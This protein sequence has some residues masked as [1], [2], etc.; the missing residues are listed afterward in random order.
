M[1]RIDAGD[2]RSRRRDRARR[3]SRPASAHAADARPDPRRHQVRDG[4]R[5]PTAT[6][7]VIDEIHTPD[8][9]RYWYADDYEARLA[10]RRGAALARQ[11]VRAALAR[12]RGEV[13]RR[14]PAAGDAR[15]HP[16]R[17]RAPLH[18]ELRA[19]HRHGRSCPTRASR[20]RASRRRC[21][22]PDGERSRSIVGPRPAL[23]RA[24]AARRRARRSTPACA[25]RGSR[26]RHRDRRALGAPRRARA[27]ARPTPRR[28]QL[29]HD[30]RRTAR[31]V[32]AAALGGDPARLWVAP[33]ARHDVAV[34]VEGDRHRARLRARRRDRRASSA[35]SSTTIAGATAD[36]PRARRARSSDRMTET[37]ARARSRRSRA[38]SRTPASR[39]AAP[40]RARA[41]RGDAARGV[42]ARSASRSPPTRSTYLVGALRASSAAIRPTSS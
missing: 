6:I 33:R 5:R 17:G 19:G 39:A 41:D 20:S 40:R 3:C 7:V 42:D 29:E 26:R 27:R 10:A 25:R 28:A 18:R 36:A 32:E 11:G 22:E 24:G 35:R 16:R 23:S 4:A 9:S 8:S 34:V 21:G 30:A 12:G 13:D 2:V 1:G 38:W 31:Q 15:R 37:R 14:R